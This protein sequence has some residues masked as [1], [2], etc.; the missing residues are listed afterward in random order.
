[1]LITSSRGIRSVADLGRTDR[2]VYGEPACKP[3]C[4][5]AAV[6]VHVGALHGDMFPTRMDDYEQMMMHASL[7]S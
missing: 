6:P 2:H 1:M 7:L 5:R 4:E 3:A